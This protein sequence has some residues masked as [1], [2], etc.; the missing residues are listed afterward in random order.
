MSGAGVSG[1]AHSF[2]PP[3]RPGG[4][5][6]DTT[7]SWETQ[8]TKQPLAMGGTSLPVTFGRNPEGPPSEGT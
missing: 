1:Q 7:A 3:V 6:T 5:V 2:C 4:G 8:P